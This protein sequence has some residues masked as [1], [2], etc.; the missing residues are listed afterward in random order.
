MKTSFPSKSK[1]NLPCKSNIPVIVYRYKKDKKSIKAR[2]VISFVIL[3]L[4]IS[5]TA[6]LGQAYEAHIVNV[7]AEICNFSE[8]RTIGYWKNHPYAYANFLPIY[9]GDME[10]LSVDTAQDVFDVKANFMADML[11]AQLLAM[12]FNIA[13]F[14]IGEYIPEGQDK[15]LN[16]IIEEVDNLLKDPN[17][18]PEELKRLKDILDKANNLH[19]ISY[20]SSV[21]LLKPVVDVTYPDGGEEWLLIH[22]I[23]FEP[24]LNNHQITWTAVNP[25]GLDKD[26]KIDIWF[27]DNSGNEC[28]VQIADNISNTGLYIWDVPW[29]D[30]RLRTHQARIIIV[31]ADSLNPAI[32]GWDSSKRNFKITAL[33]ELETMELLGIVPPEEDPGKGKKDK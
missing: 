28:L 19:Q 33:T 24:G 1:V 15:N 22:P 7:T 30:H 29:N 5:A 27:C 6:F 18:S 12:K 32:Q 11:R 16:Q 10:V 4:I 17:A 20:C 14:G 26:L 9:L 2:S 13:Q 31:A 21:S 23:Y 8:T 25:N 3:G